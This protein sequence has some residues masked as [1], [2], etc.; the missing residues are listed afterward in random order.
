MIKRS[1][2]TLLSISLLW[3]QICGQG[4]SITKN[5]QNIQVNVGG[6]VWLEERDGLTDISMHRV[7]NLKLSFL[8]SLLNLKPIQKKRS[9]LYWTWHKYLF[10]RTI[11][12]T[13]LWMEL[14]FYLIRD[15]P[16]VLIR[17]VLIPERKRIGFHQTLSFIH[18]TDSTIQTISSYSNRNSKIGMRW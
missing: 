3:H 10:Y 17:L 4:F 15:Q 14:W 13:A 9:F 6:E 11:R 12:N 2:L 18:L 7:K 16:Q 1:V 8:L 5:G